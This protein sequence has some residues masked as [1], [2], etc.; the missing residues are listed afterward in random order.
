MTAV[1]LLARARVLGYRHTWETASPRHRFVGI[2]LL[3]GSAVLFFGLTIGGASLFE[4]IGSVAGE[5]ALASFVERMLGGLAMF[6][7]AGSLPFV[8]GVFFSAS[9]LSLTGTLP[10]SPRVLAFLRLIEACFSASAQ[11]V[12]LGLPLALSGFLALRPT[13]LAWVFSPLWIVS[14]LAIPPLASATLLLAMA[15]I[16]GVRRVR[17]GVAFLSVVLAVGACYFAISET[18]SLTALR[19]WKAALSSSA[20]QLE[21][22]GTFARALAG[23]AGP[24]PLVGV[25]LL[26]LSSLGGLTLIGASL[27]G[28][29]L[30]GDGVLE[31]GDTASGLGSPTL[32]SLV[33]LLPAPQAVR[34]IV[35]KDFRYVARDLTL[36]SQVGVPLILYLVPFILA[37]QARQLGAGS[38]ELLGLSAFAVAFIAYMVC[39]ILG[40]SSVGLEGRGF[41]ILQASPNTSKQIL[42]AK[43]WLAFLPSSGLAL[44]LS[45]VSGLSFGAPMSVWLGAPVAILFGC[46]ALCGIEVG[47]A[48][49]FPRFEFENPAHRASVAALIWGFVC[50][51]AYALLALGLLVVMVY[52]ALQAPD[53]ASLGLMVGGGGAFLALS[54]LCAI[55][56]L[57]LAAARLDRYATS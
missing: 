34:A 31:G 54:I 49:L 8:A 4:A 36:L 55:L 6:L 38:V 37:P 2:S 3:F 23:R 16:F 30:I 17:T 24:A 5:R 57:R 45:A 18:A 21:G 9:D 25:G 29:V 33:A 26:A 35:E 44:V 27:G 51:S 52:G 15:R 1:G 22:G 28:R 46:A 19:D 10:V 50:A 12:V 42:F 11:F 39:S 41:W 47:I 7:L 53:H 48:G 32:T 14:L 43:W 56:P 20:K 40:L 13:P